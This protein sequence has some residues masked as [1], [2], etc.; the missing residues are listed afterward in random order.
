MIRKA[1]NQITGVPEREERAKESISKEII[2]E[3]YPYLGL[4]LDIH[5]HEANRTH[6][7][8]NT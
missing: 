2:A 7:Y 6:Y 8:V 1:N 5:I 3:N 4:D